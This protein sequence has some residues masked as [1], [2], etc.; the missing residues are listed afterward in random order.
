MVQAERGLEVRSTQRGA[1]ANV[2]ASHLVGSDD[3]HGPRCW[4]V[5]G[6]RG[7]AD[8]PNFTGPARAG[9]ARQP[10]KENRQKNQSGR[11]A[12]KAGAVQGLRSPENPSTSL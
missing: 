5:S 11:K 10:G 4:R 1:R 8:E 6:A 9:F 12:M 2:R 7:A 3:R